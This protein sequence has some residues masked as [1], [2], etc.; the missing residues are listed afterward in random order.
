M[1]HFYISHC[2][3]IK[4][5]LV[6]GHIL[7]NILKA[8]KCVSINTNSLCLAGKNRQKAAFAH[9]VF[10]HLSVLRHHPGW[11]AGGSSAAE[12]GLQRLPVQPQDVL[13]D[14]F[15]DRD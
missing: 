8:Q 6:F 5:I 2:I 14:E 13:E 11:S 12:Q 4:F 1:D 7:L 3:Y 10:P 15:D 9:S